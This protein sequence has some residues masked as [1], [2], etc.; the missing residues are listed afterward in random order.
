MF[1]SAFP[2]QSHSPVHTDAKGDDY[3]NAMPLS[4]DIVK[5]KRNSDIVSEQ[6]ILDEAKGWLGGVWVEWWEFPCC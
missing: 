4:K 6:A 3:R 1:R 2:I 5:A